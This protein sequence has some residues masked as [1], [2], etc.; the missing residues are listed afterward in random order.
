[1][2]KWL[3][4]LPHEHKIVIAGNHDVSFDKK[5]YQKS[6][7]KKFNH[8]KCFDSD[9][10]KAQLKGACTYLEDELAVVN[11]IR[12]WGSPWQPEFCDWGF[13]LER[14]DECQKAWDKIPDDIHVLMTH[15]PALGF[16]DRCSSGFRAGCVNLLD[17]IE[18]KVKPQVHVFGHIHED[19]GVETNG[20]TLF[21]NGST[22]N[23]Q[24]QRYNLNPPI[25]F[26]LPN[27]G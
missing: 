13:N 22:S 17:M 12:I 9:E 16:G 3:N 1:M 11:G 10:L 4:T 24:Y 14:G 26:D 18:N 8:P 27:R 15:G 20:T 2:V 5:W 23:L 7:W 25:V 21:V 6:G 19:H